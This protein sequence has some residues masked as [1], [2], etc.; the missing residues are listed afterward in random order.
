MGR[1]YFDYMD[2]DLQS[3]YNQYLDTI[4][5][6]PLEL[7]DFKGALR[8]SPSNLLR[9]TE[10]LLKKQEWDTTDKEILNSIKQLILGKTRTQQDLGF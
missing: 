2:S 10:E 1:N 5:Y 3:H 6:K 7:V 9:D 8:N 4:F